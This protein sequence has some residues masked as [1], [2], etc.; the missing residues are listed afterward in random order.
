MSDVDMNDLYFPLDRVC[1]N[2]L[3]DFVA[4]ENTLPLLSIDAHM[5]D[6][7]ESNDEECH[8]LSN[9][10]TPFP[11][12]PEH[13]RLLETKIFIYENIA[14]EENYDYMKTWF[15]VS[16]FCDEMEKPD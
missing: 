11:Q 5:D 8:C 10:P 9:A 16:T 3:E 2:V 7:Y 12:T 14:L 4:T 1:S 6:G 13:I 15:D